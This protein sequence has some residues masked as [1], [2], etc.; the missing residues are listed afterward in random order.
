MTSQNPV[1]SLDETKSILKNTL[2][3]IDELYTHHIG[4]IDT[5]NGSYWRFHEKEGDPRYTDICA[6]L[7][8]ERGAPNKIFRARRA[9]ETP[10]EDRRRIYETAKA[11]T[12]L[13]GVEYL[14]ENSEKI[15]Q[16][17]AALALLGLGGYLIGDTLSLEK[18]VINIK[19]LFKFFG[20]VTSLGIGSLKL[21]ESFINS[22]SKYLKEKASKRRSDNLPMTSYIYKYGNEAIASIDGS[23]ERLMNQRMYEK[24][25]L[26]ETLMHQKFS[27]SVA[28]ITREEFSSIYRG[29]IH[30]EDKSYLPISPLLEVS[31]N[32]GMIPLENIAGF[33]RENNLI[34]N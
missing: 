29:L 10:E 27:K 23:Y 12:H 11:L 19:D 24:E 20:G 33:F 14:M 31:K 28:P 5:L 22:P 8:D 9:S 30:E 6:V 21:F 32:N 16:G 4:T 13:S 3:K 2:L 18:D 26:K 7:H 34:K 1:L 15:V 25:K 17:T